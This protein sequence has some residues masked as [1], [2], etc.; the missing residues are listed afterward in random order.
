[1]KLTKCVSIANFPKKILCPYPGLYVI[2]QGR[3]L[4]LIEFG[5]GQRLERESLIGEDRP[6]L[7][8]GEGRR[9]DEV[10]SFKNMSCITS[11]ATASAYDVH[12]G[13]FPSINYP[14]GTPH[15]TFLWEAI[16]KILR[17]KPSSLFLAEVG[18]RGIQLRLALS[19]A[20]FDSQFGFLLR[21]IRRAGHPVDIPNGAPRLFCRLLSGPL[22][23]VELSLH[24]RQLG[25][26]DG[27]LPYS[28]CDST[29]SG[30]NQCARKSSK[31]PIRFDLLSREFMLLILASLAGCLFFI[32]GK[33]KNDSIPFGVMRW[34]YVMLFV[35]G[36][37][38]VHL[39][40]RRIYGGYT[41]TTKDLSLARVLVWSRMT[42]RPRPAGCWALQELVR[43]CASRLKSCAM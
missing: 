17:S 28:N 2:K 30:E 9:I 3:L 18:N 31:P 7:N 25:M 36:Q 23:L 5:T 19:L 24:G 26:V 27:S 22:H 20:R 41:N 42:S 32:R 43:I 15:L 37:L 40:S 6:L 34:G 12:C 10:G 38:A 21:P 1:M 39:L 16:G 8:L 35:I 4:C 33:V 11:E 13:T 14:C 29:K